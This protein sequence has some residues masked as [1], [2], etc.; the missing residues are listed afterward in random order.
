MFSGIGAYNSDDEP[1]AKRLNTGRNVPG[2]AAVGMVSTAGKIA[3]PKATGP[4]G[5]VPQGLNPLDQA[6]KCKDL[7]TAT[8]ILA[9]LQNCGMTILKNGPASCHVLAEIANRLDEANRKP[10]G[11]SSELKSLIMVVKTALWNDVETH[12]NPMRSS[13][14][15]DGLFGLMSLL[16]LGRDDSTKTLM[17]KAA[18]KWASEMQLQSQSMSSW[19]PECLVRAAWCLSHMNFAQVKMQRN[20]KELPRENPLIKKFFQIWLQRCSADRSGDLVVGLGTLLNLPEMTRLEKEMVDKMTGKVCMGVP[21]MQPWHILAVAAAVSRLEGPEYGFN[22][23]GVF[24]AIRR[25][26]PQLRAAMPEAN[27]QWL[28]SI[29]ERHAQVYEAKQEKDEEA[30]FRQKRWNKEE[31]AEYKKTAH[32]TAKN[33]AYF[34][35]VNAPRVTPYQS[36]FRQ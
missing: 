11:E 35:D 4:P 9:L 10:W 26:L 12:K 24:G 30:A 33:A 22:S 5:P 3:A 25:Q 14:F 36:R 18:S 27:C 16:D 19:Q 1:P 31:T 8:D 28:E 17:T 15:A 21:L 7:G 34:T 20:A 32:W 23:P 2:P 29:L 6:R 13:S